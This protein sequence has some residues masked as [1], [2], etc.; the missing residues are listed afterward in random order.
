MLGEMW[1][2]LS[3]LLLFIGL[4]ASQGLLLVVGSLVIV[5]WLASRLWDRYSFRRVS[6]T[7][8]LSRHRAFIGDTLEYTVTLSNDKMLPLI[9]VD[10]QDNFPEGLELPGA[11]LRGTASEMTRHHRITT[12]MLPYQRVSWKYTLRCNAR[13]YHR[14]GPVRLRSGDIFGFG[15]SETDFPEMEHLLVYPRTVDLQQL[16]FPAQHPLGGVLGKR[17]LHPDTSRV[18]GQRDYRPTDPMKHID[19]KATARSGRLQTKLFEPVVSLN[20]LVALNATT[21]EHAWQGSNRRFFERAVT[22]AASV[23]KYAAD[24]GYSFGLVSNAVASYSGKWL[25]VPLGASP[26]QL[27]LVL[28]AL[29]MAGPYVVASLPQV[30]QTERNNLPPGTTVVLVTSVVTRAL[31][32]EAEYITAQGYPLL[33]LYAGDGMP[34][35]ELPGVPVFP[36]G[37]ALDPVG[38]N[39][40]VLAE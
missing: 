11:N 37:E 9:W 19:W 28:E 30:L 6:H 29:A 40:S 27:T 33:M 31:A 22:A 26:S 20:V 1:L 36:V 23:A 34:E 13:G 18:L 4:V 3:G 39:E 14:I 32:Q 24:Q 17:P 5:I 35:M 12:S 15:S 2:L 16:M 10:I 21:S 8:V 25:T 38:E 7:R